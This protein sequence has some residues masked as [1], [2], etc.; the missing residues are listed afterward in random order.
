MNNIGE[1]D[2]DNGKDTDDDSFSP[3]PGLDD[4]VDVGNN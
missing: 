2:G 3:P 4:K 1:H